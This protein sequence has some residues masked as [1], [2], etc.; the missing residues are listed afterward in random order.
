MRPSDERR[1][2]RRLAAGALAALAG[3]LLPVT[4]AHAAPSS[5]I[6]PGSRIAVLGSGPV[7]ATVA[8]GDKLYLGGTI[9]GIGLRAKALAATDATTGALDRAVPELEGQDAAFATANRVVADGH[10]GVYV[11]DASAGASLGGVPLGA[12]WA[13]LDADGR[14]DR[15]LPQRFT[16]ALGTTADVVD[17]TVAADGTTYLAGGF[18]AVDGAPR[19]GLA[20]IAADGSLLPWA[21]EVAGGTVQRLHATADGVVLVGG[22][23]R[24]G[25]GTGQ[26]RTGLALVDAAVGTPRAWAPATTG[27]DARALTS[28]D[29]NRGIAV[30]GDTAYLA[31]TSHVLAVGLSGTGT[32]RD[33]GLA[34]A[35]AITTVVP[36]ASGRLYVGGTF[37]AIGAQASQPSRPGVAEIATTNGNAT[38]WAPTAPAGSGRALAVSADAVY[39]GG[40]PTGGCDGTRAYRRSDASRTAWDPR[41]AADAGTGCNGA[42][43]LAVSGDRVWAAGGSFEIANKVERRGYAAIDVAQDEILPWAPAGDGFQ[44]T[45]ADLAVSP[46]GQTVY[47][48][49]NGTTLNGRPRAGVAAVAAT[50]AASGAADVRTWDP[51]PDGAVNEVVPAADGQSVYLGGAFSAVGGQARPNLAAV[52]T[53]GTGA[54]TSWAP[55]VNGAVYAL[56]L[57]TDGTLYAGGAFTQVGATPTPRR[58]LA[59]FASGSANPTAWDPALDPAA[60]SNRYTVLDLALGSDVVYVAGLFNGQIGG[61]TRRG[62][63]ALSRSTG[64]ATAWNAE[65]NGGV[66][67]V[68]TVANGDVYLVGLSTGTSSFREVRGTARP[69]GAAA[70]TPTGA[71]TGWNPGVVGDGTSSTFVRHNQ[72]TASNEVVEVAGRLI[73]PVGAMANAFDGVRQSGFLSFAAATAPS[74]ADPAVPPVVTGR[75]LADQR[76]TCAPGVY[77]GSRPF[78]RR[79]EWR[80]D[81]TAIDGQTGTSYTTR[82]VDVGKR[83]SCRERVEN[84][85]GQL[86]TVSAEL[87]I[88][89]GAPSND[90]PPS[91][92][93]TARVGE[94]VTCDRGLWSNGVDEYTYAW[95]RDG[96]AIDGATAATYALTAAD[97]ERRV[98]CEVTARNAAGASTPAR[99]GAVTVTVPAGPGDPPVQEPPG[100]DPPLRQD[101]PSNPPFWA[102]PTPDPVPSVVVPKPKLTL[103][104]AA[105]LKG[106]AF[107]LTLRPSAAGRLSVRATVKSGKRTVT[108]ARTSSASKKAGTARLTLKPTSAGKRALKPGRT[109]RVTFS[110][111]FTAGNGGKVTSTRTYKV[112]VKR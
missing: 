81:G 105:A 96:A 108:V 19:G 16:T 83:L 39:L 90:A 48:A 102:P 66:Q 74:A 37:T 49:S 47:T 7:T 5:G 27:G 100:G 62:V 46:D 8:H 111:T 88:L 76:L 84:P 68:S 80:R 23:T 87:T 24:V 17:A 15:G 59:A 86:E 30:D 85:A 2:P 94:T 29:A 13:R 112:K 73:V 78:V 58:F 92:S 57:A 36:G 28:A 72:N 97:G 56:E 69:G 70:L 67:T 65:L 34:P 99:S 93:G 9:P 21:P 89:A 82:A 107:R 101:P 52:A 11:L 26:S 109:Y 25:A 104:T 91:V 6:L 38:D 40:T 110:V 98:A 53:T 54:A 43:S 18:T 4:P 3:A 22:F 79:Y 1:A 51:A 12:S 55:G 20:A 42:E 63:A 61:Q 45:V 106:R 44:V 75:P 35:G 32:V 77:A 31:S 50:G 103:A 41:L 95:L 60:G 10:G 33:L 64:T 14:L 71:V